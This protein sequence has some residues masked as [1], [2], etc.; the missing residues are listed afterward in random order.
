MIVFFNIPSLISLLILT[1]IF[2][3]RIPRSSAAGSQSQLTEL[4]FTYLAALLRGSYYFNIGSSAARSAL[5]L[6]R[7]KLRYS[8]FVANVGARQVALLRIR[9][10]HAILF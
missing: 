9:C 2:N 10:F 8:E 6:A 7:N 4:R 3:Q 5:M 1:T